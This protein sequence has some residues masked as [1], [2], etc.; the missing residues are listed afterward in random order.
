MYEVLPVC[1]SFV[2]AYILAKNNRTTHVILNFVW[3][4][5]TSI[6]ARVCVEGRDNCYSEIGINK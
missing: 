6:L 1:D 3:I 2:R 5:P 4:V